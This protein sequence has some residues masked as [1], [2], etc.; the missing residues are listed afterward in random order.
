MII[1]NRE[2]RSKVLQFI[3]KSPGI[4]FRQLLRLTG[5]SNGSLFVLNKLEQ[6]KDIIVK[7]S[8]N[9]RVTSYYPKPE[10]HI[11]SNLKKELCNSY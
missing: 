3:L 7:R 2:K 6:S 4:R 8:S 1:R 10:V 5:L 9:N 11:I